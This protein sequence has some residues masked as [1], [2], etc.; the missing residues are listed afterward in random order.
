VRKRRVY[1]TKP[2]F[3]FAT[4]T[5]AHDVHGGWN[6]PTGPV[7]LLHNAGFIIVDEDDRPFAPPKLDYMIGD[8]DRIR[9]CAANYC[10]EPARELGAATVSIRASELAAAMGL[11]DAFPNICQV[12]EGR[13]LQQLAQV[14]PPIHT[15]PNPSSSTIFTY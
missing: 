6:K 7:T 9:L 2:I 13:K 11:Q 5:K 4:E 15:L 10:I 8:A 3:G 14:P 1:P 12:L